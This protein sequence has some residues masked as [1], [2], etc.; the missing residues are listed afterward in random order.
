MVFNSGLKKLFCAVALLF[1]FVIAGTVVFADDSIE[2]LYGSYDAY[3]PYD[4][5]GSVESPGVVTPDPEEPG[6][7]PEPEQPKPVEPT[8][9][10]T[11]EQ[12]GPSEPGTTPELPDLDDTDGADT[13]VDIDDEEPPLAGLPEE[14]PPLADLPEEE[15][16]LADT[17][18]TPDEP[19]TDISDADVPLSDI[20]TTG[21]NSSLILWA[22]LL[23]FATGGAA[24]TAVSLKRKNRV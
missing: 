9:V 21:D 10:P 15:P 22:G 19:M 18:D 4:S 2:G 23:L 6:V 1:M 3:D 14:E 17:P 8:P 5:Y 20:P 13:S 7:T 16:P 11:P 24:A 12:P